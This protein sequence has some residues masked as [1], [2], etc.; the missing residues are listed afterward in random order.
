MKDE[1]ELINGTAII[2]INDAYAISRKKLFNFCR[3]YSL[4][5]FE[6]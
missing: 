2:K 6:K 5:N 3:K 4:K 1:I